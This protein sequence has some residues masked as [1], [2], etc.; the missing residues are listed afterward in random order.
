MVAKKKIVDVT[1]WDF[2]PQHNKDND[3]GSTVMV[4]A[5][6]RTSVNT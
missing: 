2:K 1:F 4:I 3:T 6:V 5:S